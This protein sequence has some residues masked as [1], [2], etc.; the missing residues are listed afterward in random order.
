MFTSFRERASARSSAKASTPCSRHHQAVDR[1]GNGLIV[2]AIA[3]DGVIEA[4]EKPG[5]SFAVAVQWHPEDRIL[6]SPGD[7]KLFDALAEALRT[8]PAAHP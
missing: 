4:L 3:P 7:R 6:L 8:A 2:S 1:P 5:D